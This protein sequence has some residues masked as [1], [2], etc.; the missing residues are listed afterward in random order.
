MPDGTEHPAPPEASSL[1]AGRQAAHQELLSQ[2]AGPEGSATIDRA[3]EAI[4]VSLGQGGTIYFFG[5][6][7][8]AADAQHIAAEL[9]GRFRGDRDPLAAVTL[10]TNPAILTAL[11]NDYGYNE[12]GFA[13]ELEALAKPGDVAVAF[14]TSGRS[15]GVLAAL[16]RAREIGL[17]TIALT[18]SEHSLD[19]LADQ[20]IAVDSPTVALIQEIHAVIGH[21]MCEIVEARLGV[22]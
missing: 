17:A 11:A 16:A 2:L 10:G 5:N 7:G 19:G 4:A 12:E 8:S 18:G 9:V 20:V 3:A 1:V 15:P 22:D 21:V 14:S 6:G 13:R